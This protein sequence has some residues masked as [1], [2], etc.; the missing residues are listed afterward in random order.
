MRTFKTFQDF[1][2][3]VSKDDQL[4]NQLAQDPSGTIQKVK[5]KDKWVYR[6]AMWFLGIISLVIV[7]GGIYG[8]S[9][10]KGTDDY[11]YP[12][13]LITIG[14]TAVGAIAGLISQNS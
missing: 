13:F 2:D 10:Y 7:A 14:S 3:E 8:F 1:A 6:M 11:A 12:E 4:A 9:E 5:I